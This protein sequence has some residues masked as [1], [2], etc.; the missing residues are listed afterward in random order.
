MEMFVEDFDFDFVIDFADILGSLADDTISAANTSDLNALRPTWVSDASISLATIFDG[1]NF[2]DGG[3]GVDTIVAGAGDDFIDPGSRS[4]DQGE[5]VDGGAGND[6]LRLGKQAD[7]ETAT[8]AD[9]TTGLTG[10]GWKKYWNK[11]STDSDTQTILLFTLKILREL[12]LTI[13]M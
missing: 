3:K 13:F 5:K 12:S 7:W 2:I 8:S 1:N 10:T 6:T 11:N 4:K 9:G